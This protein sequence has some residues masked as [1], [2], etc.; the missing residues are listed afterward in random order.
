VASWPSPTE[1]AA[2]LVLEVVSAQRFD[3]ERSDDRTRRAP[4]RTGRPHRGRRDCRCRDGGG[5]V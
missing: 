5:R 1:T 4:S 3:A 2:G